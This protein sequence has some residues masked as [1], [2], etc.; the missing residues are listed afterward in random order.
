M[1]G[2]GNAGLVVL[3]VAAE[4]AAEEVEEEGVMAAVVVAMV[5]KRTQ[6]PCGLRK[7]LKTEFWLLW[8]VVSF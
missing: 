3:I 4:A 1:E 8:W 7:K 5:V 6:A 2:L